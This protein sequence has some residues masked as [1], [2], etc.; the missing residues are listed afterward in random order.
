[1][2]KKIFS[3]FKPNPN[4]SDSRSEGTGSDEHTSTKIDDSRSEGTGSDHEHTSTKIDDSSTPSITDSSTPSSSNHPPYP[5]IGNITIECSQQDRVKLDLLTNS[6]W[7]HVAKYKFPLRTI[8]NVNRSLQWSWLEK[9]PWMR[10]S[11]VNDA[12]YCAPCVLFGP[13]RQDTKEKTFSLSSPVTDWGN[14]SRCVS[15]HINDKSKHHDNVLAATEFLRIKTGEKS[16]ILE[17]MSESFNARIKRNREVLSCIIDAILLCGKQNLAIRGHEE[18]HSNFV[19][20]LHMRAKD[21]IV[22]ADHLAFAD[23]QKKYTSP[24]I[25]NE[26]IELCADQIISTLVQDCNDSKYF[27]FMSDEATDCSTKEQ[28]SICVRFFDKTTKSIREEFLGFAEASRTTGEALAELF[29]EQLE[30]KGIDVDVLRQVIYVMNYALALQDLEY[31]D[32]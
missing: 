26:L 18:K 17:S 13:Q 5:D 19:A 28:A 2:Q 3:Y 20:L 25:Q 11:V 31:E 29:L 21:N 22:L 16:D 10:Y 12:V 27:G 9:Y 32:V 4:S 1:M 30:L 7:E 14:L 8:R 6:S 23:P 24:D 15:R